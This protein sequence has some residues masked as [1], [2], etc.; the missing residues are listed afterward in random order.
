MRHL[1]AQSVKE[2]KPVKIGGA[3]YLQLKKTHPKYSVLGSG[4]KKL[5]DVEINERDNKING[6][7]YKQQK[8]IRPLKFNL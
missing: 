6:Q 7:G 1:I 4:M 8:R 2:S 5:L 3:L